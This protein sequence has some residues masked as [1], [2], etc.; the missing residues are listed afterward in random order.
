MEFR[1][2]KKK[3][4]MNRFITLS[5]LLCCLVYAKAERV[6]YKDAEKVARAYYYQT[7]NA[8]KTTEWNDINI[9]CVVNPND[10]N[11]KYNLYIFDKSL[12]YHYYYV[13]CISYIYQNNLFLFRFLQG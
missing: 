7:V 2:R 5:I 10:A 4:L 8:F 11:P 13:Y 1:R 9:S 3:Y 12:K 6:S